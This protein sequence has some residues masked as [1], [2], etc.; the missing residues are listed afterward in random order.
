[1]EER[2][3]KALAAVRPYLQADGGDVRFVRFRSDGILE[4][5]WIGTC[6]ICPMSI[7]TLRAGVERAIMKEL[8]EVKRVEAVP[9]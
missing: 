4:V 7:L 2:F 3:D 6:K 8:P 1:M 9:G 5:Q